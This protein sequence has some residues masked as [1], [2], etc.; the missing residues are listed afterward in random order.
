M[1]PP[2]SK[3]H[4]VTTQSI[5][6]SAGGDITPLFR[7]I[8]G[9]LDWNWKPRWNQSRSITP[10]ILPA[11]GRLGWY[12]LKI[13]GWGASSALANG[14][15]KGSFHKFRHGR[16][17]TQLLP[18]V[19][20]PCIKRSSHSDV[21]P[22]IKVAK[23]LAVLDLERVGEIVDNYKSKGVVYNLAVYLQE[24]QKGSPLVFS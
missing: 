2:K 16:T 17:P 20:F 7:Y 5:L 18:F 11:I 9:V 19:F 1:E 12:A 21:K 22:S 24:W 6:E 10:T 23:D 13:L 3:A 14:W 8:N 15:T 4:G